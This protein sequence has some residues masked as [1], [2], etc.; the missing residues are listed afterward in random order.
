M[1][2][3]SKPKLSLF[4]IVT[5]IVSVG[6]IGIFIVTTVLLGVK[7]ISLQFLLLYL[8]LFLKQN[9]LPILALYLGSSCLR[10]LGD[11]DY[12]CAPT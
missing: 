8:V 9:S 6:I 1:S 10:L 12:R 2:L 7:I 11:K 3:N 4:T 5:V